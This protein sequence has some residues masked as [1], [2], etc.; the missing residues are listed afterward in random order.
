[1][2][3]YLEALQ[4]ILMQSVDLNPTCVKY[5]KM[6]LTLYHEAAA[7]RVEFV[8]TADEHSR[9]DTTTFKFPVITKCQSSTLFTY[10]AREAERTLLDKT[11]IQMTKLLFY[12]NS[13]TANQNLLAMTVGS[14]ANYFATC[15]SC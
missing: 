2:S 9:G 15:L 3:C 10:C 13:S 7:Q 6:L 5:E 8:L 11:F 1:M 12:Y 14:S 4:C